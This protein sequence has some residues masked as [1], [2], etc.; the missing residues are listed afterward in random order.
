MGS[1]SNPTPDNP[2]AVLTAR[3]DERL[4]HVYEQIALADEQ[5]AS[6]LMEYKAKLEV[7]V[8]EKSKKVSAELGQ[9]S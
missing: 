9:Q 2:D 7:M 1:T 5:L 8:A 3:T 6:K 4:A